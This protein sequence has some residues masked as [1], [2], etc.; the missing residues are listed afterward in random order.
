MAQADINDTIQLTG[1]LEGGIRDL[2]RAAE[3]FHEMIYNNGNDEHIKWMADKLLQDT[4]E[5]VADFEALWEAKL[6][7][8]NPF[9]AP[10][11]P[12]GS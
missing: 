10:E 3:I 4:G 12:A 9:R 7:R 5:L 11:Q 8:A 1:K 6:E 2:A